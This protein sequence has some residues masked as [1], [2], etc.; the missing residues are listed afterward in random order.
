MK[1]FA[2]MMS[3][4]MLFRDGAM[5]ARLRSICS[6]AFTPQRVEGMRKVIESIADELLDKVIRSGHMDMI[7]DFAKPFPCD[8]DGENARCASRR[9]SN[10][11]AP[12][13]SI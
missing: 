7:A 3:Q 8:C 1:P 5:H 10:S 4:Q 11:S 9:S 12:G 6:A 2:E 13:L